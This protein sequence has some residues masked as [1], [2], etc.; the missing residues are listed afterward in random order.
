MPSTGKPF[1]VIIAGGGIAGLVLAHMLEKFNVDY[2]LLESH[3]EI[4]PTI[5]ASIGILPNG[6][7]ILDQLDL[8]EPIAELDYKDK[9]GSHIHKGNGDCLLHVARFHDHIELRYM[10][11]TAN[12]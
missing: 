7:R 6:A 12:I 3:G 8:Y 4:G 11:S 1:K 5:G 9:R 2:L 10:F